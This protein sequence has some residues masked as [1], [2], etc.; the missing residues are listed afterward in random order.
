MQFLH[1]RAWSYDNKARERA[2]PVKDMGV[3]ALIGLAQYLGKLGCWSALEYRAGVKQTHLCTA[4][5]M[6]MS[7]FSQI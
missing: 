4:V 1:R 5:D 6:D 2:R 7:Q 3:H